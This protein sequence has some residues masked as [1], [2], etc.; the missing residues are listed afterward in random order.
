MINNGFDSPGAAPLERCAGQLIGV[1]PIFASAVI[2]LAVVSTLA[3][4]PPALARNGSAGAAPVAASSSHVSTGASHGATPGSNATGSTAHRSS[5][6]GSPPQS[7]NPSHGEAWHRGSTPPGWTGHGEK[8]GWDGGR[9]PPGL[10]RHQGDHDND[11]DYYHNQWS[12]HRSW[13]DERRNHERW[14]F[15]TGQL[16][17]R[18]GW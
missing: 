16:E 3:I 1:R 14:Q 8:R 9:M 11:H 5:G 17:R 2:T 18:W 13:G 12:H 10:S 7:N 6:T 4:T 15:H